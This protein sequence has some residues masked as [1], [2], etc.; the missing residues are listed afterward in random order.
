MGRRDSLPEILRL[1]GKGIFKAVID[2]ILPME[3]VADAHRAIAER[4]QIGKILLEIT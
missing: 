1:A 2:R 4:A 3:K